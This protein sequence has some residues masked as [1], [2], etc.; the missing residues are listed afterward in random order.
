MAEPN[1]ETC[2][3]RGQD[4]VPEDADS[5]SLVRG[6]PETGSNALVQ[7]VCSEAC[8]AEWLLARLT[9][10]QLARVLDPY[11]PRGSEPVRQS[12]WYGRG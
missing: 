3:A 10:P 2:P 12:S 8:M 7:M 6:R 5:L 9:P 11:L 4:L 1:E